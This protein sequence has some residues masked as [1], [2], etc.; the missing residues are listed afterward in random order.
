VTISVR[1][2]TAEDQD[3]ITGIVRRARLNPSRLA[4]PGFVV[5]V[6]DGRLVGTAQLRLHPDGA[7]ELASLV[8][9]PAARRAGVATSMV[10][11]LLA[12]EARPVYTIIDQR[13]AAHFQRWGFTRVPADALPRSVRHVL[14]IGRVVTGVASALRK[15]RIRLVPLI[16]PAGSAAP[17]NL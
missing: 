3:G 4:W 8:V 6:D 15:P 17:T 12:Q 7:V 14:R 1:R 5:A 2:A 16:R 10:D 11:A 13:Y 9:E